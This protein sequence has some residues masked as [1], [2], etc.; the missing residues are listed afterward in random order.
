MVLGQLPQGR[1][2]PDNSPRRTTPPQDKCPVLSLLLLLFLPPGES[3]CED[4]SSGE[5][6]QVGVVPGGIVLRGSCPHSFLYSAF[7]TEI[8]ALQVQCIIT[9]VIGFRINSAL[10]VHFLHSL[11]S[12]PASRY[13]TGPGACTHANSPQ[14]RLH[15]CFCWSAIFKASFLH[16]MKNTDTMCCTCRALQ[17]R[18]FISGNVVKQCL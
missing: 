6:R 3:S 8:K 16:P 2:P 7:P 5:S 14:Y 18:F 9:Q 10:R 12:M 13:L 15:R 4:S 11:G 17:L 1:L